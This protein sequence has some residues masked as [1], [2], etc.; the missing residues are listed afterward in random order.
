MRDEQLVELFFDVAR[1]NRSY[2]DN[3]FGDKIPFRGQYQ[4]LLVLERYRDITQK[5]LGALLGIR[6]SSVSELLTKLQAKGLIIRHISEQDKRTTIVSLT[7]E[8]K[9]AAKEIRH[10]KSLVH[11]DMLTNLSEEEK[12]QFSTAL[13]KIKDFYIEMGEHQLE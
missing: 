2:S 6:P 1:L 9:K 7:P 3:K 5:K 11:V 12:Q 8:G 4:C 13:L 10:E